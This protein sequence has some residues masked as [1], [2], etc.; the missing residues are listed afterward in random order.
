MF[1]IGFFP[2]ILNENSARI[3]AGFTFLLT[4]IS[5]FLFEK[6]IV[7]IL[8]LGFL[9][10]VLWGP[11]FSP[12]SIL[13][14]KFLIPSFKISFIPTP[15][16]PKRFAQ[17]IGLLFSLT[18]ILFLYFGFLFEYKLTLSILAFFAFLESF[19]GFCAG[20]FVFSYLMKWGIIPEEICEKC[21]NLNFSKKEST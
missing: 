2:D 19:L 17:T 5:I 9:V 1:K 7:I 13:V 8:F 4:I 10:R 11:K 14:N 21:N 18:A 16:P 20:C 6:F 12:T 3:V 15:G